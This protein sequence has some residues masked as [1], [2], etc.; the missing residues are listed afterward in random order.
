MKPIPSE[1]QINV[2]K[3][4]TINSRHQRHYNGRTCRITSVQQV[5]KSG[6]LYYR[7]NSITGL[8]PGSERLYPVGDLIL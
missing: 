4:A 7:V 5:G 6:K 2:G 1:Y 8:H 3:P